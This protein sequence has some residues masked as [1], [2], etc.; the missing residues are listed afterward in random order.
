MCV[1]YLQED[2]GGGGGEG[3][4]LQVT[5]EG[6]L[7]PGGARTEDGAAAHQEPQD[8]DESPSGTITPATFRRPAKNYNAASVR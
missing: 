2:A 7:L 4:G 3:S 6:L 5:G 1:R 8:T